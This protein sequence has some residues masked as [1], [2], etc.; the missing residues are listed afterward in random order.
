MSLCC[1]LPFECYRFLPHVIDGLQAHERDAVLM[2]SL[3]DPLQSPVS[4]A[5]VYTYGNI[6]STRNMYNMYNPHKAYSEPTSQ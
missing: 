5:S 3:I 1:H 2:L 6:T 4:F